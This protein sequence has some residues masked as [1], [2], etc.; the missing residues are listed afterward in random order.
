MADHGTVIAG[1][2]IGGLA[3]AIH[4][5]A[6]GERV[7]LVEAAP[8]VGGKLRTIRVDGQAIDAGPTVFTMRG[9]FQA[10]FDQAGAD[11]DRAVPTTPL[12]I[13]ARHAWSRG[14]GLDL[15]ADLGR[16]ADAIGAF[17]G[18]VERQR[19]L[20]FARQAGRVHATLKGPFLESGRTGPLGLAWRVGPL[21]PAA[22]LGIR[23]FETLWRALGQAFADP[24][25]RQ[26]FG[27]YAT[28]CGSSPFLA[29]AT[30][31]L[32]AH[33]EQDGVWAIDGGMQRL[34]QAMEA[35][36]RSLGVEVIL[37]QRVAAIGTARGR[38]SGVVLDSGR[39]LPARAVVLNGDCAAL[40][41]GLFGPAVR[42]AVAATPPSRR[43]LS[44]LTWCLRGRL[45]GPLP[46]RHNVFFSDDY[47]AEFADLVDRRRMP[48]Q[49]TVYLCAQDRGPGLPEPQGP[50]RLLMLINAPA[51]GDTSPLTDEEIAACEMQSRTLLARCGTILE[52]AGP[53]L[54]TSPQSFAS[55]FPGT[56]GAL[57]G[58][59]SHGW[60]AS[61]RRPGA[62]TRVPGLYL[63]GGSVHPGAGVPMA[64]LSGRL[65]AQAVLRD[66]ASTWGWVPAAITGGTS[67]ASATTA[68]TPSR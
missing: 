42:H 45:R 59:A 57:Y 2:G 53:V 51:D 28:Y 3:C 23:P 52:P 10:L 32:I 40:A 37:G 63:T 4:L 35:L 64:A 29:P 61:F 26:L 33:V 46:S 13:L 18:P 36:A 60:R 58:A 11:F 9:V 6:R 20:D 16:S 54:A 12:D 17:A 7:T 30:L 41:A 48:R 25:L 67:T 49:P 62:R 68:A 65:A 34:A 15:H 27:R 38:V 8:Q 22:L 50:E 39:P 1:A 43:S 14:P 24:R 55:L 47:A 44:A 31:M 21:R 56:G 19:F 5:A 66:R